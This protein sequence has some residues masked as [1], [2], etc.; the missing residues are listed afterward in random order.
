MFGTVDSKATTFKT[1]KTNKTG[2]K[3]KAAG[4]HRRMPYC[5]VSDKIFPNPDDLISRAQ[6]SIDASRQISHQPYWSMGNY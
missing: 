6:K 4:K 1:N 5:E 2:F 3:Q